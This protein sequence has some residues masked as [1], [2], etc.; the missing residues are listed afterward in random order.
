MIASV[1]LGPSMPIQE[2]RS[3]LP[4]A[5][6]HPPAAQGD[7]LAAV[8]QDR[9][10]IVG[11]IDGTFHQNLSV[12]HSEVCYLLSRGITVYG[13]S[14]MGALRAVETDRFGTIGV[15]C[16]YR[17]YR[18]GVV[19]GDDEV[20]LRHGGAD[21]DFRPLSVPLVNIR[22]SAAR[23]VSEGHLD[24][25]FADRLIDIAR[26]LYYPERLVPLILQRCRESDFPPEQLRAAECALTTDYVDLK[27]ADAREMLLA[28]ASVLDGSAQIPTPPAFQFNRSSVFET[29]Y[30][31]DRKVRG[32]EGTISLQDIAEHVALHCADFNAIR[33][34]A[35]DRVLVIFLGALLDVRVTQDEIVTERNTFCRQRGIDSP[36]VLNEW[37]RCNAFCEK[38][39]W[40]YLAQEAICRRLRCTAL[41]ARSFDRGCKAL[42]DE[43]RI[44]G[45]FPHW[46][47]EASAEAAIVAAYRDQ[48]EYR[49]IESEHP[50]L[51]AE[52]HAAYG[53]VRIKGDARIWAEEAG[54]DSVEGL[55][56]ALKRSA[57]FN[58]VRD[59]ISRQLEALEQA[60]AAL[61]SGTSD[62]LEKGAF[63]ASKR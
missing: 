1:F 35:L 52:R 9:A 27:R 58:D 63:G 39:L 6:F 36:D 4:D 14:S 59:R 41:T 43:L 56:E 38:D 37:L 28:I 23:A 25:V 49:H 13:A 40:E 5:I 10:Q 30:N 32:E 7:L 42:I 53:H 61:S 22:A 62:D 21:S 29:L 20:A 16:I 55:A 15:G 11:L 3:I 48:P 60:M 47:N 46:A 50:G 31:L 12:W 17:W 33:R 18:D 45:S 24:N 26:S 57:I 8:D 51:L 19:T 54:F 44:R 34:S 2:A